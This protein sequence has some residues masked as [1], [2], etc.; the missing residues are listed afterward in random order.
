MINFEYAAPT[1]VIFGRGAEDAVGREIQALGGTNVMIHFGAGRHLQD[2]GL[3]ERVHNSLTALNLRFVDF[4]G[5]V[6]NPRMSLV[7]AGI[8]KAR[9]EGVDFILAI[10]GGSA[11]DSAKAIAYGLANDFAVEDLF[12]GH[13]QTDKIYPLGCISTISAS[14]SETSNSCVITLEDGMLKRAYNHDCSRPKFAILNPEL[15]YTLPPYQTACGAADIMMHTMERYFTNTPDV[16]LIDNMSEGLLSAVREAAL[17][18]LKQPDNYSARATLM[19]AGSLSHNG[20]LG[21]GRVTDFASHKIEHELGGMF[22]VAHGAG[23][24]AVWGS[25]ARYVYRTNVNRFAQFAVHVFR[26]RPNYQNLEE[27]ALRGIEAWEDWCRRLA[28]PVSLKELG[29]APT[30]EQLWE[31]ARKATC[32]GRIGGFVPLDAQMVHDILVMAR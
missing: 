30:D 16:E 29:L 7:K 28:M 17:T 9:A 32:G 22:D 11:I 19:W 14:G 4:G 18:A 8:A 26:V 24:C 27:T 21:T 15:T 23:L 13:A 20:L 6:P 25:W 2:S 5:A 12:L 3:L 10:G 31:M 1:K